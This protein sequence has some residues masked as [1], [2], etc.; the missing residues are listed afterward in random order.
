MEYLLLCCRPPVPAQFCSVNSWSDSTPSM[1]FDLFLREFLFIFPSF[2]CKFMF[3][4]RFFSQINKFKF[5]W[6]PSCE[7]LPLG[8][9]RMR[10]SGRSPSLCCLWE[11][12][13]QTHQQGGENCPIYIYIYY[14]PIVIIQV[15]NK[16]T[17]L[18][19]LILVFLSNLDKVVANCHL[20]AFFNDWA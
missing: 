4:R 8:W 17:S 12:T 9:E 15:F 3:G 11:S 18:S 19:L 16:S 7:N 5:E 2:S 13:Q 6:S 14:H 20:S 1:I 10:L